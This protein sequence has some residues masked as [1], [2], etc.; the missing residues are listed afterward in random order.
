MSVPMLL[1][2]VFIAIQMERT[3]NMSVYMYVY[4]SIRFNFPIESV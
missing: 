3:L 2:S 1:P 4:A